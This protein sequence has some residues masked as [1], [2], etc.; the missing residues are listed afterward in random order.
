MAPAPVDHCRF[1]PCPSPAVPG[2]DEVQVAAFD[3]IQERRSAKIGDEGPRPSADGEPDDSSRPALVASVRGRDQ[4]QALQIARE[5]SAGDQ[6]QG[7]H[8][9]SGQGTDLGVLVLGEYQRPEAGTST[10]S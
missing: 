10:V 3:A 9:Q 2:I 1:L 7:S 4:G 8:K 6:P 5:A